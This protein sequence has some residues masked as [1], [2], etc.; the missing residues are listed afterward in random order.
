MKP[1]GNFRLHLRVL[2]CCIAII[3]LVPA[4][5]VLSQEQEQGQYFISPRLQLGLHTQASLESPITTLIS[6]GMAVEVLKNKK[7]FSQIKL[8][9]GT[10]GWIKTRFLTLEEPAIRKIEAL[11]ESLQNALEKNSSPCDSALTTEEAITETLSSQLSFNEERESYEETIATLQEELKAWEQLDS[12]DKQAKQIQAEKNNQQLKQR[13]SM[14]ASL[15]MGE[16]VSGK[17]FDISTLV[18]I[19]QITNDPEQNILKLFKKNYLILLMVSG[20]S[21]LSGIFVMD[22]FNR[23]RHGGY[24]V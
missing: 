16:E 13:L 22:V 20:L 7:E 4:P 24:R 14:I 11:E 12:Q 1:N 10:E 21:F 5:Q 19:P 23:R 6:S 17:Q 8:S 18:E 9:D 3:T 2:L 15:A